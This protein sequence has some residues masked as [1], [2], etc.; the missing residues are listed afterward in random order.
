MSGLVCVQWDLTSACNL[1]CRHCREK[2]TTSS[3]KD[4]LSIEEC[5]SVID[6][7][8]AR[9]T[10]SLSIAGGEPIM[11]PIIWELLEYSHRKFERLA[12]S[13]NG[14]L[15]TSEIAQR[16]SLYVDYCQV[17][18]DGAT[19]E[20]HD[21]IRGEGNFE[22]AL[23]GIQCL[24]DSGV[25]LATRFTLHRGNMH[26]ACAYVDLV[27]SMGLSSAHIRR[28]IPS[29][30]AKKYGLESLSPEELRD[31]V[32]GAIARGKSVGIRVSSEESFCQIF[33]RED[34]RKK[35]VK[36]QAMKGKQVGGC[37][38]GISSLYIM[39]NGIVAYCPYLPVF[40][41]DLRKESLDEIWKNSK[42]M[43]VARSIRQNLKGKCSA[44]Q[45]KF[46]CGGCRAYAYATTGDILAEDSGCWL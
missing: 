7:L 44:C 37:A 19:R 1:K 33:F 46:A 18:L 42:M 26:E 36:I 2:A 30:N 25:S 20:T 5:K 43:R 11:S 24:K 38:I 41:G 45:Y 21:L 15:I 28:V 35:A 32:G 22:K 27:A 9:N 4:D 10:H 16:L 8:V 23:R 6:Q 13:S 39:Q 3:L 12:I 40:C 31:I 29:G 14:T 17:S 34:S